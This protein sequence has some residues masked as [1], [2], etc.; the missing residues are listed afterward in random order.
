MVRGKSKNKNLDGY[1]RSR[2]KTRK[3]YPEK[4]KCSYCWKWAIE[5][6][7]VPS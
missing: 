6:K 2:S 1:E 4:N 7:I 3:K 5:R